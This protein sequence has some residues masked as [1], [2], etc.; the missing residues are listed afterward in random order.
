MRALKPVMHRFACAFVL[1][2]GLLCAGG[3]AWAEVELREHLRQR[4]EAVHSD[5][6]LVAAGSDLGSAELLHA[7]YQQRAWRPIWFDAEGR[8]SAMQAQLLAAVDRAADHG[9][10]PA[11]YHRGVLEELLAEQVGSADRRML[12][13]IE[14]L[15]SDGLLSL[16]YHLL[17]GRVDPESIDPDWL[18]RR[19]LPDLFELLADGRGEGPVD[20]VAVLDSLGPRYP[21]YQ[22]LREQLALKRGLAVNSWQPIASGPLVRPET[23]DARVSA[24]RQ[25]LIELGDLV[26]S[27]DQVASDPDFYDAALVRAV[28]A[29]QDR[30]GLMIDGLVGPRTLGELNV[31]PERRVA[32][33]R[34]NLERWRW[35]P[36]DLGDEYLLVNIA[37]YS[38]HLRSFGEILMTQRV[39]VGTPFRRTPVFSGSMSYLVL[40]PSWEVPPRLA[41]QDILPR[42][43]A[44]ETYL[45]TMGFSVYQGWGADEQRIDPASVDWARLSARNFPYRLRQAPGPENAL[46]RVKFMFPN[47]HNVYLHDTPTRT[48]FAHEERAFSSGC[49]RIENPEALTQ[50][51][52][53]E[54]STIMTPE[55]IRA[56]LDSGVETTVRL[57]RPLPVHLLYWTAWVDDRGRVQYR[58]DIYRRDPPLIEAL[59]AA[60]D[61]LEG[62]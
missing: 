58:R 23:H 24:I 27:E 50:W 54:R 30:H 26:E 28:R 1:G 20:L 43:R 10:N 60:P 41:G 2:V 22:L 59:D 9:L 48:L 36:R 13:D 15:A 4:L 31:P 7:L 49:I 40:N 16:A 14:L 35:L 11:H 57:D 34:A 53:N 46:G 19:E 62:Y 8:P 12:A 38:M 39:V 25:R 52:L 29:F 18:L 37:G 5:S 21:A 44:D 61:E 56:V 33:L 51:L 42:I 47:R 6:P 17:H 45:E 55:R 32:Q 3:A